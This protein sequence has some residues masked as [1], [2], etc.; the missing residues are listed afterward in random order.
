MT[1][2]PT[3]QPINWRTVQIGLA[4]T[5]L[6][7]IGL[8]LGLGFATITVPI[9]PNAAP[10]QTTSCGSAW[11]PDHDTATREIDTGLLGYTIPPERICTNAATASRIGSLFA[12]GAGILAGSMSLLTIQIRLRATERNQEGPR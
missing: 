3:P 10:G 2:A 9:R 7:L 5:G 12:L 8:A 6:V 11:A 4:V 1:G